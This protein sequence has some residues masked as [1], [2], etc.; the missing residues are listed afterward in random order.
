MQESAADELH[1]P[2]TADG[3]RLALHRHVPRTSGSSA[4][5]ILCGG[6]ACN[7]H[8]LDYDEQ[9][10]LA[11]FLAGL[12]F[13]AWVVE[14]RGRGMAHPAPGH[15]PR[16]SWTFDDLAA[17]DVP[18]A[19]EH[20]AGV[21]GRQVMWVGHSMGGMLIYAHCGRQAPNFGPLR[22]AVTLAA[23]VAFPGTASE[24]LSRLGLFLLGVPFTDL[25]HQRW[26]L[27]ALWNLLGQSSALSV[28]MNPENIDRGTVGRALRLSLENVPRAKLQ[29]F[30]RWAHSGVFRSVDEQIDY[31]TGLAAVTLPML[32][33][34]GS[35][36][37]L[38]TP[39]AVGC[40]LDH[41]PARSATYLEFGRTHGYTTDYGHV[42]IILGQR[43]PAE[44]FPAIAH[45]LIEHAS[46]E[47]RRRHDR[48]TSTL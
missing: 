11:R 43:A 16:W 4:P 9:Y 36:D 39:Q 32:V 6:Y 28:G 38:A 7:R 27:G 24:L 40:A 37:R 18:A 42:D 44:V 15:R 47:V 31:R 33:V 12:G 1:F 30:A 29:Q 34:A 13:D 45:W 46:D 20:V 41:L 26:A 22:A 10:S 8:F 3:W 14:L 48:P 21:T 25:I 23:P 19:I 35:V 2:R 5:V 17:F